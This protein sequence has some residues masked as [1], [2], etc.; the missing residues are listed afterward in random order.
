MSGRPNKQLSLRK[1]LRYFSTLHKDGL[2]IIVSIL[3]LTALIVAVIAWKHS[4]ADKWIGVR[5]SELVDRRG[6]P[7]KIEKDGAG[8]QIFIYERITESE[9][10]TR[11]RRTSFYLDNEGY[12]YKVRS[13]LF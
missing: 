3:I 10:G 6:N 9:E 5:D 8:G 12:I 2:Q 11:V 1:K 7:N 4:A 13:Y